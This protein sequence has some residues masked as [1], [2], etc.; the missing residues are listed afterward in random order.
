MRALFVTTTAACLAAALTG[1]GAGV[2]HAP[3]PAQLAG[4]AL[5]VEVQVKTDKPV[6][7]EVSWR[8]YPETRYETLTLSR[9][10]GQLW[11]FLPTE[12]VAPG[13]TVE[14]FIDVTRD[15]KLYALGTPARPYATDILGATEFTLSQLS[16][17]VYSGYAG[18]D[19]RLELRTGS[20]R[21]G[22]S[23]G[24]PL[25]ELLVPGLPGSN[26]TPM[27]PSRNGY[28]TTIDGDAVGPGTWSYAI[29]VPVGDEIFRLPEAGFYSFTV[30]LPPPPPVREKTVIIETDRD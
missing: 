8:V 16:A 14:Y 4:S 30:Q 3:K 2:R 26:V 27:D 25:V 13:S 1:C 12:A 23:V 11:T 7:G 20:N 15:G 17:H 6:R 29:E 28:A 5:P 18:E 19:V 10:A 9:R 24:Q 21:L 22:E